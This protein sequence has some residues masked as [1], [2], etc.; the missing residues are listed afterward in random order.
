MFG[1]KRKEAGTTPI[2]SERKNLLFIGIVATKMTKKILFENFIVGGEKK[3][4][5]EKSE[6]EFM[7][8]GRNFS[9]IY[10]SNC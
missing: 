10:L 6:N 4:V 3:R 9:A 7:R 8:Y 5:E 2:R 1:N